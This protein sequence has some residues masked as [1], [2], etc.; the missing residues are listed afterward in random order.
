MSTFLNSGTRK[1]YVIQ[2][3]GTDRPCILEWMTSSY[4][5]RKIESFNITKNDT[6]YLMTDLKKENDKVTALKQYFG[7]SLFMASD[8]EVFSTSPF[9]EDN[10]IVFATEVA[11]QKISDG[12]LP[13]YK[14]HEDLKEEELGPLMQM[15]CL[16]KTISKMTPKEIQEMKSIYH[17]F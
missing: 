1:F 3:R 16:L 7:D 13:T 2:L 5:I 11:P 14:S 6:I 15:N 9:N 4:L 12:Y 8:M 17:A 10:Y